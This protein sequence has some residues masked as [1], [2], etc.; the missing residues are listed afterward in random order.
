MEMIP[1]SKSHFI[2]VLSLPK[3]SEVVALVNFF[4]IETMGIRTKTNE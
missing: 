3:S 1:A 2:R 4:S